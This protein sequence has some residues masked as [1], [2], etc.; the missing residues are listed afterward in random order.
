VKTGTWVVLIVVALVLGLLL[1]LLLKDPDDNGI[2]VAEK[3]PEWLE[4]VVS[5]AW[6]AGSEELE[7]LFDDEEKRAHD[8]AVVGPSD[9]FK[10]TLDCRDCPE[11]MSHHKVEEVRRVAR[12][13][14]LAE[15]VI[16]LYLDPKNLQDFEPADLGLADG[17]LGPID[18][19]IDTTN[20]G[21][22]FSLSDPIPV[23]VHDDLEG[24]VENGELWKYT[25]EVCICI[26]PQGGSCAR[27]PCFGFDPHV[28][29]HER[30]T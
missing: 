3:P 15:A 9:E 14:E 26:D 25:Y 17:D 2:S 16:E 24:V 7:F 13:P 1:G 8:T 11:D 22:E 29:A 18:E 10:W 4:I 19:V 5:G 12:L 20:I 28:W 6:N 30:K 21:K 27:K 23:R